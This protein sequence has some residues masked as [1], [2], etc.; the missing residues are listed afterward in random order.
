MPVFVVLLFSMRTSGMQ[1]A[2]ITRHGVTG[3]LFSYGCAY[4][5]LIFVSLIYNSL[6]GD[7]AGVQF[8]F[9]APIRMRDVMLAKNLMN[10]G[11]FTIEMVLMFIASALI[12]KPAPP[13]LTVATLAWSVFTLLLNMSIGNA[14]SIVSPKVLDPARVRSQNVST[15]NSLI[16]LGVVAASFVI[17]AAALAACYWMHT[18]YWPAALLFVALA[19]ASC[20]WYALG[21]ARIDRFAW[22]H[23]E[24]LTASLGKLG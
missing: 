17:G 19:A 20:A 11:I 14:R 23:V 4:T 22:E 3:L 13:D 8:Y 18:G 9:L 2:G 16:S 1:Y 10:I 12:S 15:L 24:Q 5:Q 6:G 21:L 7:G